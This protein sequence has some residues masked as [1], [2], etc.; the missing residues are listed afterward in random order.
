M[1]N[2]IRFSRISFS[3]GYIAMLVGAI[4]PLE[5]SI[6]ILLG[7]GLILIGTYFDNTRRRFLFLR[8]WVFILLTTGVGALWG[9][10]ALG[11]F[12]GT[13][14]LS[15]WWGL[16]ILPYP[17]GWLMG[18]WAP[19]SPRWVLWSG[20]GI[21]LFY[22]TMPILLTMTRDSVQLDD[23]GIAEIVLGA[24]GILIIAG[25]ILRLRKSNVSA[26]Y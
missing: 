2:A 9:S 13:S 19:D 10:S 11:G 8:I 23:L 21:G 18:I 24:M 5:G 16:L 12:G 25:C 4:D 1:Q 26:S 20:I 15:S 7:S 3:I 14:E 6:V 22:L 17:I